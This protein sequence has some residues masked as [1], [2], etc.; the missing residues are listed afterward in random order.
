MRKVK[1]A[2][3]Y[4]IALFCIFATLFYNPKPIEVFKTT[5]SDLPDSIMI[6]MVDHED[7]LVPVTLNYQKSDSNEENIKMLFQLMKQELEI[8]NFKRLIPESIHCL[9]IDI[10]DHLVKINLNEAFYAMNTKT[11]LRV[12]EG[13]VSSI[14]QFD[15]DYLVEFYVNQEK[16]NHM[17]LSHLPMI[18]FNASLGVNNFGVDVQ[19]LH[20]S[21][22]KQVVQLKD[23]QDYEYYVVSTIRVER[24]MSELKFIN[25]ILDKQ[26]IELDCL[27]IEDNQ[28][29]YVL[30]L[31]D[32][33]LI[34]EHIIDKEKILPLLYSLKMNQIADSF[35]IKVNNE[36]VKVSDSPSQ[37][38]HFEDLNLNVFEE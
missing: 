37:V 12:I 23:Q 19:N 9:E 28:D 36:I 22:S 2:V 15:N 10:Q 17:P 29:H 38:I 3:T 34:E 35:M 16:V 1:I 4:G 6:Y 14:M 30:H 5:T 26:S 21:V 18:A 27:D 13:I 8:F 33:F 20:K 7:V 25:Y 31:N 32:K 11:E 24:E